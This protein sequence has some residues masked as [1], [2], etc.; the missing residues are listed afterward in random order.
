MAVMGRKKKA[1]AHG[2]NAT[3]KQR[4]EEHKKLQE[5]KNKEEEITLEEHKKRIK[6]LKEIGLIK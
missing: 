6:L 2:W 1:V 4:D 5:E 3:N